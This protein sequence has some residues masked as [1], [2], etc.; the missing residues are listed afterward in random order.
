MWR[1][2]LVL[3]FVLLLIMCLN[4]LP[5]SR[6]AVEKLRGLTPEQV[7]DRLGVPDIDPR[8]PKWGSWKPTIEN[9]R[10]DS[11]DGSLAPPGPGRRDLI[12]YYYPR[13]SLVRREY[14]IIFEHNRVVDVKM[15]TD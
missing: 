9:D 10:A 11:P 7:I 8:Q 1:Y 6:I 5:D 15:G 14:A 2:V 12:F 4:S 3:L 13:F